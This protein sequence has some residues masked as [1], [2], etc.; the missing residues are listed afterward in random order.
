MDK[1]NREGGYGI[2]PCIKCGK[3][4]IYRF[5]LNPCGDCKKKGEEK[6]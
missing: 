1:I 6:R 2:Y 5:K 3:K 4:R